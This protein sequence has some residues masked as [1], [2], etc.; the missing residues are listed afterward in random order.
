MCTARILMAEMCIWELQTSPAHRHQYGWWESGH[1]KLDQ[2][3]ERPCACKAFYFFANL[4]LA[5]NVIPSAE[6][7]TQRADTGTGITLLSICDLPA[8]HPRSECEATMEESEEEGGRLPH[9]SGAYWKY[10]SSRIAHSIQTT[11]VWENLL[12]RCF[13]RN[14]FRWKWFSLLL[15]ENHNWK[16]RIL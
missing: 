13:T 16:R 15:W 10:T 14:H 9:Y 7:F 5:F 1:F 4:C 6:T 12:A 8:P 3:Q 11:K 2:C